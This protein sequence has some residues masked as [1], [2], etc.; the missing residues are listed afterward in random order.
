MGCRKLTYREELPTLKVVSN[1][2]TT[3]EKSSVGRNRYRYVGKE[4]DE[5]SGMYYYGARYYA[6]WLCRF[7]SVDPLKADYPYLTPY[8][9]AGNKPITH[10]DID[11]L[12][13]TGDTP[14]K[15]E[16]GS[17]QGG[18][19][20]GTKNSTTDELVTKIDNIINEIK[21][22]KEL[23]EKEIENLTIGGL[24]D[25]AEYLQPGVG[26]MTESEKQEVFKTSTNGTIGILL[27]EFATG[28]G[29]GEREFTDEHPITGDILSKDFGQDAIADFY[30][31]NEGN[32]VGDLEST[33]YQ[34]KFSPNG[35]ASEGFNALQS[36]WEHAKAGKEIVANDDFLRLFLGGTGFKFNPVGDSVEITMTDSK[37][38][39]SLF[40]HASS[41]WDKAKNVSREKGGNKPL[42]TTNQSYKT[43]Q[44][45]D[46]ERLKPWYQK[47]F[48]YITK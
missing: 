9:Y 22:N 45:V 20:S 38:R 4:K 3:N 17:S 41:V 10:M 30:D 33:R 37:T 40:L 25:V 46:A 31:K 2:L 21:T 48:D 8:N 11:G 13:S 1:N 6:P 5:E 27:H 35:S 14:V 44:K 47:A 43:T 12:Q 42:T 29:E 24:K 7:V 32:E 26:D 36:V 23:T 28:T 19:N 39:S 18:G 15:T 16:G 34:Y